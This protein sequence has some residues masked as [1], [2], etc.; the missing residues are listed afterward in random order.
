MIARVPGG[1]G[2]L[3]RYLG[4]RGLVPGVEVEVMAVEPMNG[5]LTVRVGEAVHHLGREVAQCIAVQ[6]AQEV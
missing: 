2:E 6:A 1:E 4:E 5:P 3:L